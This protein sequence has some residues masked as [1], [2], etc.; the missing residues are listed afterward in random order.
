P[1]VR[2]PYEWEPTAIRERAEGDRRGSGHLRLFSKVAS[3]EG[4]D[5]FVPLV[6]KVHQR[7]L[8]HLDHPVVE[9]FPD[10]RDSERVLHEAQRGQ[11]LATFLLVRAQGDRTPKP[12]DDFSAGALQELESLLAELRRIKVPRHAELESLGVSV[13]LPNFL[14]TLRDSGLPVAVDAGVRIFEAHS[15]ALSLP[16]DRDGLEHDERPESENHLEEA[17]RTVRSRHGRAGE[18]EPGEDT[19]CVASCRR[20]P[21]VERSVGVRVHEVR[22]PV[23]RLDQKSPRLEVRPQTDP[24]SLRGNRTGQEGPLRVQQVRVSTYGIGLNRVVEQGRYRSR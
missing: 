9:R 24:I 2:G 11:G 21:V 22:T 5:A 4:E 7:L 6:A 20:V 23:E 18:T 16:P 12:G 13:Q 17:H 15:E 8:T 10:V 19:D 14:D 3:T 1:L